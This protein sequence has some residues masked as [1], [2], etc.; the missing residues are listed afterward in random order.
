MSGLANLRPTCRRMGLSMIHAITLE[1][2]STKG[3]IYMSKLAE[4]TE[5][6]TAAATGIVDAME[7]RL[8][9]LRHRC[10]IDRRKV[11]VEMTPKGHE[12]LETILTAIGPEGVS[13]GADEMAEE[14]LLA[15]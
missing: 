12:M 15:G 8:L 6:S 4:Q 14:G 5:I 7:I 13:D 2:I 11:W 3:R 1:A 10:P 9:V